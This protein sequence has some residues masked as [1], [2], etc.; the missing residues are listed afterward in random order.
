M[1]KVN[2]FQIKPHVFTGVLIAWSNNKNN[3]KNWDKHIKIKTKE[4]ENNNTIS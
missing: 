1:N 3:R 4:K 2:I